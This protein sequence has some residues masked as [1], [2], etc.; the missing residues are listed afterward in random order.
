M[1]RIFQKLEKVVWRYS[2]GHCIIHRV[3][4][5]NVGTHHGVIKD[6]RYFAILV[7]DEREGI[8][9]AGANAEMIPQAFG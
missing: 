2:N 4:I 8:D 1:S 6:S 9:R 3:N 5:D 7:V